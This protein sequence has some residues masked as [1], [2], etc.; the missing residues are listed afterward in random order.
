[1]QMSTGAETVIMACRTTMS[2]V[3]GWLQYYEWEMTSDGVVS[4]DKIL[5]DDQAA[6]AG[7]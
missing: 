1:M 4:S 7:F 2:S 3:K 5:E 6:E